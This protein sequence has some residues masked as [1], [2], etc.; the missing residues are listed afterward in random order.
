MHKVLVIV[1]FPMSEENRDQRRD[2]MKGVQLGPDISFEFESVRVAP[3]NYVS[4]Y[5]MVLA[6]VHSDA[7]PTS[8]CT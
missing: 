6:D 2:Q 3:R 7:S 1:P 5:E 8:G 4:Q